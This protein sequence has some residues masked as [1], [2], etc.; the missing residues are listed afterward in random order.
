MSLAA[1]SPRLAAVLCSLILW[2]SGLGMNAE[3]FSPGASQAEKLETKDA[4]IYKTYPQDPPGAQA[5]RQEE[6]R[7]EAASWEMLRRLT[8]EIERPQPQP[9]PSFP[10]PPKSR[11]DH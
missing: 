5:Q 11:R 4:F 10:S 3:R 7:K 1:L 9:E 8:I 2:H 6:E